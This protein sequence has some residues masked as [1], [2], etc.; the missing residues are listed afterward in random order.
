MPLVQLR[1][2]FKALSDQVVAEN[3][4]RGA[5]C[6]GSNP[7]FTTG[8]LC[9]LGQDNYSEKCQ[10]YGDM[11]QMEEL[12]RVHMFCGR[13]TVLP[14]IPLFPLFKGGLRAYLTSL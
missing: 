10:S 14:Q 4:G 9:D 3:R 13:F 5:S 11:V 1:K 2:V 6:L 7:S 8:W 12:I